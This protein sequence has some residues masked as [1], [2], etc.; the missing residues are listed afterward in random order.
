MGGVNPVVPLP[1][2]LGEY[3]LNGQWHACI[4]YYGCRPILRNRIVLVEKGEIGDQFVDTFGS[5]GGLYDQVI[6]KRLDTGTLMRPGIE[7]LDA[8]DRVR[9][10]VSESS[11]PAVRCRLGRPQYSPLKPIH[12][13]RRFAKRGD[14]WPWNDYRPMVQQIKASCR[15]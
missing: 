7:K 12:S 1:K 11:D 6:L 13:G 2:A 8:S 15:S 14:L 5:D 4:R 3:R 9:T 10:L